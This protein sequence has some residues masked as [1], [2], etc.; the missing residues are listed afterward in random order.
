MAGASWRSSRA[1][2]V[3]LGAAGLAVGVVGVSA[4][5]EA[6][7]STHHPIAPD[8]RIELVVDAETNGGESSQTTA[9]M[10]DAQIRT[11]RLEVHSDLAGDIVEVRRDRF[12]AVLAP[13]MDETDRRQF[14][15][16]LE[17]WVIDNISLEVV[18]LAEPGA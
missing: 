4:L 2:T 8:S 18:S 9:E 6:T 16:C 14:R 12:R 13:S 3:A 15:G 7:M 1:V 10:V 11:C 5:R 17:D